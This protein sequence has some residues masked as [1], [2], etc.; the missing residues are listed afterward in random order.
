MSS[1][2][3]DE[4]KRQIIR[5]KA[6]IYTNYSTKRPDELIVDTEIGRLDDQS[7]DDSA[8]FRLQSEGTENKEFRLEADALE[9]L[10]EKEK[11]QI[12]EQK[13]R[14]SILS[15]RNNSTENPIAD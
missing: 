6:S 1:D 5:V 8:Q 13:K 4:V 10:K 3:T 9:A 11:E 14:T 2:D 12:R 7:T 15:R